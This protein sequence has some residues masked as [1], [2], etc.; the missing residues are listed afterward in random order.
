M[1]TAK[2]LHYAY[3]E[4]LALL[5]QSAI[6]LE[7][8]EGVIYAM[9]GG[10]PAHADLSA[11]MIALLR[12]ALPAD[13]RVYSSDLKVRIEATDL[14][15]FPDASVVC[16]GLDA[17]AL[18]ANAVTNP[19]ILVEVSSRSTEDYDR[20]D[21]L[22]HYKQLPSLRAVL[23]VSHRMARVTVVERSARGWDER[24]VRAGESV[25]LASPALRF[26]VDDL[27]RGVVLDAR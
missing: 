10:T 23:L 1:S 8:C 25:E 2:R 21:K 18:D 16:G 19:S 22:S 12:G 14:S 9:A 5:D 7:Y 6:K 11:G 26:A 13:C 15:T 20:G 24:D 17:S 4:Y 27:Y 3:D